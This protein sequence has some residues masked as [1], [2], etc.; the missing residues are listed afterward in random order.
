MYDFN[1]YNSNY[2]ANYGNYG[3]SYSPY[4]RAGLNGKMV[5]R[6]EDITVQDVPTSG[7][8]GI[9]PLADYSTIYVKKWNPN[10]TIATV[11]Y[12]PQTASNPSEA[13]NVTLNA[14]NS[15]YEAIT[16]QLEDI[17]NKITDLLEGNYD[18]SANTVN[19]AKTAT[20]QK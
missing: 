9:F 7:D 18:K 3:N 10:G 12:K 20:V 17:N 6:L 14:E 19:D 16:K 15:L 2:N 4:M 8:C 11:A 13:N 5:T 1:P